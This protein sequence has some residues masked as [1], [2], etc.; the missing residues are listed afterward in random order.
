MN[1][2]YLRNFLKEHLSIQVWCDYDGCD[3]PQINVGLYL[4]DEKI[5]EESDY[6][7][8]WK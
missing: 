5:C 3:S 7:N 8:I 4:D 1:E 6:L 2:E